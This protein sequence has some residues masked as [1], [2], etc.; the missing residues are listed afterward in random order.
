M[1]ERRILQCAVPMIDAVDVVTIPGATFG[2]SGEGYLRLS[3][4]AAGQET[5]RDACGRLRRFFADRQ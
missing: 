1:H 4:G 5:L 3:Y 2:K